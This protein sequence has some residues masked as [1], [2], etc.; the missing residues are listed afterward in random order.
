MQNVLE[1]AKQARETGRTA[2]ERVT[3][4][5]SAKFTTAF[6]LIESSPHGRELLGAIEGEAG[7]IVEEADARF[8]DLLVSELRA[9]ARAGELHLDAKGVKAPELARLLMQAAHGAGY[10]ATSPAE[11]RQNLSR[12]TA[13]LL[14]S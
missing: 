8:V 4:I 5:L 10:L 9:S 6:S 13:L 14:S 12:L 7:R 1:E 11:H 2:L 3:G